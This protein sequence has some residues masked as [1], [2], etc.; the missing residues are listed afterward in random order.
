M[1]LP[2]ACRMVRPRGSP[3]GER[4]RFERAGSIMKLS[5]LRV[6]ASVFRRP[7]E[8]GDLASMIEQPRYRQAL[9]MFNDNRGHF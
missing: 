2:R 4:L 9:L 5:P 7:G 1:E 6:V 8:D 3:P